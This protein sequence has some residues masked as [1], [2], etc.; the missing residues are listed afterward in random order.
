M[1]FELEAREYE[2]AIAAPVEFV[3]RALHEMDTAESRVMRLL[4]RLRG[5][6][7]G[8]RLVDLQDVGFVTLTESPPTFLE[9]GLIGRP[10]SIRGGIVPIDPRDFSGFDNPGYAKIRWEFRTQSESP[11]RSL[12]A[13]T[14][15]IQCTDEQAHRRFLRYWRV[16]GPFSGVTRR[17]MLRLVKLGA[18]RAAQA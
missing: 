7:S 6:R 1:S 11:D 15:R 3:W 13:T 5:M 9:L 10:W 4:F 17:E 12:L 14:T 2:I 16:V 18:E 8:Y